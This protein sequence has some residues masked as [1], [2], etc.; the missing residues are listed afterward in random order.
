MV[1]NL[2]FFGKVM[3]T[4]SIK[5]QF[6]NRESEYFSMHVSETDYEWPLIV[7]RTAF[8]PIYG[9]LK[10][11]TSRIVISYRPLKMNSFFFTY[12]QIQIYSV[13]LLNT[14]CEERLAHRNFNSFSCNFTDIDACGYRDLSKAPDYWVYSVSSQKSQFLDSYR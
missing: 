5:Q 4:F 8:Q 11:G 12:G 10:K 6:E 13:Q 14:S 3:G 9:N 1:V 2:N 7:D